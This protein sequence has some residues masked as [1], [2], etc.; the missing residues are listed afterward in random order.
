MSGTSST[1]TAP[2]RAIDRILGFG[3]LAIIVV[4]VG[5]FA[6]IIIGSAAGMRQ[7]DFTEG[8]WPIVAAVPMWGL[9]LGLA[10]IITL[11]GMTFVRNGRAAKRT[12]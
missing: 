7:E 4:S 6:A 8:L 11:L 9:P 12:R 10:M 5:C 3:A 1:P 2:I